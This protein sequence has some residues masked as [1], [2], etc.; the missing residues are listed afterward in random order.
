MDHRRHHMELILKREVA[1]VEQV[2]FGLRQV[3]AVGRG[4]VG[5][6]DL[7]VLAPY[8]QR[9]RLVFAEECLELRVEADVA[10]I[11]AEQVELYI[12]VTRAIEQ[13]LVVNPVGRVDP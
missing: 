7:V 9:R 11:V 4:T 8:D 2:I 13:R 3:A 1:G 12:L 10:A 6:K 5:G